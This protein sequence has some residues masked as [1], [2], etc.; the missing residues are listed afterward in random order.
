MRG[1]GDFRTAVVLA[2]LGLSPESIRA[3]LRREFG[4]S[5]EELDQIF[6]SSAEEVRD[7]RV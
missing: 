3:Y 4:L 5:D 7:R 1:L 6:A 2:E